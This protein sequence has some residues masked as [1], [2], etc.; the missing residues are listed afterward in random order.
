MAWAGAT[1]ATFP[2]MKVAARTEAAT[3]RVESSLLPAIWRDVIG[4]FETGLGANAEA[5]DTQ[6]RAA[7]AAKDLNI[8]LLISISIYFLA[9]QL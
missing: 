1:A 9:L 5:P 3:F 2:K 4:V 7:T 6:R 8:M